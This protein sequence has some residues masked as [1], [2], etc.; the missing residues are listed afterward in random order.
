MRGVQL[1]GTNTVSRR[2]RGANA[3]GQR[4]I[5]SYKNR[6]ATHLTREQRERGLLRRRP[7]AGMN[8]GA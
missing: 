3:V 4:P 6:N 7:R 8:G 1:R 5:D 2:A